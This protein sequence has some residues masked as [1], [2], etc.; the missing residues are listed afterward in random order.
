MYKIH[1]LICDLPVCGVVDTRCTHIGFFR[2][3]EDSERPTVLLGDHR[4]SGKLQHTPKQP[5]RARHQ[6]EDSEGIPDALAHLPA[7]KSRHIRGTGQCTLLKYLAPGLAVPMF[8]G[9]K[10]SK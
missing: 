10:S 9:M 7:Y 4:N 3:V 8:N 5:E 6:K 1:Q 2:Q